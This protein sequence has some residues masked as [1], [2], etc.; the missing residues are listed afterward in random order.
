[1]CGVI[2]VY[3]YGVYKWLTCG[4]EPYTDPSNMI[5]VFTGFTMIAV[6]AVTSVIVIL[7]GIWFMCVVYERI[8]N[9]KVV[10]CKKDD[11]E[12]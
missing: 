8:E 9:I 12:D 2:G 5:E 11:K 7:I 1:M 6:A 4:F 3:L 10:S